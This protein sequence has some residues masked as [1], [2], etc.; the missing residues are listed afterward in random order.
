MSVFRQEQP[1]VIA[2]Y[3]EQLVRLLIEKVSVHENTFTAEFK[4]GVTVDVNE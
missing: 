1:T 4:Y 2:E 3:D